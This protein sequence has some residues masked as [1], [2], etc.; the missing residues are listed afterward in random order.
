[1]MKWLEY[2]RAASL[3]ERHDC[4]EDH[5]GPGQAELTYLHFRH[6]VEQAEAEAVVLA[7][8]SVSKAMGR[9]WRAALAWLERR[10]ASDF[11]PQERLELTGSEGGPVQVRT[12]ARSYRRR[13]TASQSDCR[14]RI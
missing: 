12:P 7:V 4:D 3:C 8:D 10:H 2:G 9:D 13:W 14:I 5:H 6:M 1:M 11:K